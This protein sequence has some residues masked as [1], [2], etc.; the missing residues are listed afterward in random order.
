MKWGQRTKFD[1]LVLNEARLSQ[2][3]LFHQGTGLFER[4]HIQE[5]HGACL[6]LAN[7][8]LVDLPSQI[9]SKRS[10]HF[11]RKDLLYLLRRWRLRELAD[12]Q[13]FCRRDYWEITLGHFLGVG[14]YRRFF[15]SATQDEQREVPSRR[16]LNPKSHRSGHI[17]VTAVRTAFLL[18]EHDHEL[19]TRVPN[20]ISLKTG[21][22][23]EFGVTES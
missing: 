13:N 3:Q 2:R 16:A 1:E 11:P 12:S 18:S 15:D 6:R 21:L 19:C 23:E 10:R 5:E 8:P 9:Q 22:E 4:G 7:P 14:R 20:R 17:A